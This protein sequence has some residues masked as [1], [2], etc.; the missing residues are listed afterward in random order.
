VSHETLRLYPPA[1]V[2][3]R[4]PV[5]PLTLG[6]AQL[7]AGVTLYLSPWTMHRDP[8]WFEQPARFDPQRFAAGWEQRIDKHAYLPFGLGARHCIGRALALLQ[9][10]AALAALLRAHE[11]KTEARD[12]DR[13]ARPGATLGLADEVTATLR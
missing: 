4:E 8:R 2:F 7:P 6:D 13:L 1:W 9:A 11:L 12:F 10:K 5:A 3:D